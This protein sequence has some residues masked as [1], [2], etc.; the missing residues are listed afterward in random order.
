M[1]SIFKI[2]HIN[3]K[4]I[5]LSNII[6]K[7]KQILLSKDGNK[8]DKTIYYIDILYKNRPLYVQINKCKLIELNNNTCNA[9]L[10]INSELKEF[11]KILEEF[12]IQKVHEDSEKLFDG[13]LFTLNKIRSSLISNIR[14]DLLTTTLEKD[15]LFFNQYKQKINI[16]KVIDNINT[17]GE[18]DGIFILKIANLQFMDNFF[19]YNFV[20]E[21]SKIYIR[22][23]LDKYSIID[24]Q[25][26]N[27][28]F[29]KT[30]EMSS[31]Y[32]GAE[33]NEYH[34]SDN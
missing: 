17:I 21:Q 6:S 1:N 29:T 12:L 3:I 7:K 20:L 34:N 25:S 4:N 8:F 26:D 5:N 33:F 11:I 2:D 27:I 31:K 23:H 30:D 10:K 32:D 9:K 22:E 28:S 24:S 18:T 16:E 13:K 15:G 19:T 14:N